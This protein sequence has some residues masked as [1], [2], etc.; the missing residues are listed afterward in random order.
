MMPDLCEVLLSSLSAHLKGRLANPSL[1]L[2]GSFAISD[3]MGQ[4][5]KDFEDVRASVIAI[6]AVMKE[7]RALAEGS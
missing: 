7:S 1:S 3:A 2:L 6:C 4:K 5:Y